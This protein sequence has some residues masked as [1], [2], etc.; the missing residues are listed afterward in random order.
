MFEGSGIAGAAAAYVGNADVWNP[1][2]SPLYADLAGL[3]PLL[4]H[5]GEGEVLRDDSTRLASRARAAGV[6]TEIKVWPAVPHVWQIMAGFIP[7]G[8]QSREAAA[9]FLLAD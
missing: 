1:L 3:P 4:I 9:R 7:E 2:I 8:R 5:V 6:P